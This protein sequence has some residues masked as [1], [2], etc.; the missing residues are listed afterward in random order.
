[1]FRC[2]F[3]SENKK[4]KNPKLTGGSKFKKNFFENLNFIPALFCF[5]CPENKE[6]LIH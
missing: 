3:F 4:E 5:I 1:M 2:V 6:Y